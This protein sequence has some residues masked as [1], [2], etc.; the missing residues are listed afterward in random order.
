MHRTAYL[1]HLFDFKFLHIEIKL[2]RD[3][4]DISLCEIYYVFKFKPL[5]LLENWELFCSQQ[6]F[7]SKVRM[8]S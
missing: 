1:L 2:S 8:C 5:R 7:S 4:L 6:S 3:T